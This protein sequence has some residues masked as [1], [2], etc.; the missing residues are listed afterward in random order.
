MTEAG[1]VFQ[2][3]DLRQIA[4]QGMTVAQVQEQIEIFRRGLPFLQLERPWQ[5]SP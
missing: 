3:K 2:E 5:I 1:S 4:A